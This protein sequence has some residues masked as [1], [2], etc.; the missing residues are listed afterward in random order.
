MKRLYL[1]L[2][3]LLSGCATVAPDVVGQ[4]GVLPRFE[5][6]AENDADFPISV[7]GSFK[8]ERGYL[9]VAEDPT[10]RQVR[11]IR[12]PVI[13]IKARNPESGG[14]KAPVLRLSGGPG[15]SG[16]SAA[17]YP[18]AYPWTETRDFIILGQRGTEASDPALVCHE[19]LDANNAAQRLD[20]AKTCQQRYR[21]A[22]VDLS[23]YNSAASAA[24]IEALRRVLDIETFS[25]YGAS[26]GTRLALTY[27]RDFPDRVSSMVLDSPLPH[28][29]SFDDESADN[30]KNSLEAVS[31]ACFAARECN[32]AFGEVF[33]RFLQALEDARA[34]PWRIR[35]QK[36]EFVELS[37][38]D[39]AF[40][41][42]ASTEEGAANAPIIM[43]A[44]AR[45][46]EKL[47]SR[48]LGGEGGGTAFAWGMRLSVWCSE[49]FPFSKR[50][51]ARSE[52]SFASIDGAVVA[53]EV[54]DSW[55]VRQ[56]PQ[57]E[58]E[59]TYSTAPTLVIAG[60]FDPLTPPRWAYEAAK[61]LE[62][63]YVAIVPFGGH[64]ETTNWSGDGCAMKIAKKFFDDEEA[65][66]ASPEAA[67]ACLKERTPP[68]FAL[69]TA[70]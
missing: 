64:S 7:P 31:T 28:T 66:I 15:L 37:D 60:E 58:K 16:L 12:L 63:S 30:F 34:Q 53:P 48:L 59:A 55:D 54:C 17:A 50:S 35:N 4:T 70:G 61:T 46:D 2:A 29:V 19:Y 52:Q 40:L 43:D 5:A 57:R 36:G 38:T 23:A 27:A 47:I 68:D 65:F 62:K 6:V 41:L 1:I 24:D 8:S 51:R 49:S 3:F 20:T 22:G 42:D 18:G 44:I 14:E 39:L 10:A 45:R 33:P 21:E 69:P 13:V 56:R 11:P 26:Y 25:L 9:V 32:D 67:T